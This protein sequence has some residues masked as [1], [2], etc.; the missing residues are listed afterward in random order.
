MKPEVATKLLKAQTANDDDAQDRERGEEILGAVGK[1]A[2]LCERH[3]TL[4]S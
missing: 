3:A 4:G 1:E 2:H